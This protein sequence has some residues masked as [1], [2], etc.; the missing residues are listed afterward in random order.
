MGMKQI[1]NKQNNLHIIEIEST[2]GMP[3]ETVLRR[4]YV[5]DNTPAHTIAQILGVSYLTVVR[6]LGKAGIYSRRLPL[7]DDY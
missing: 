7:G 6:W 3:I 2:L 1:P 5:D 4:M